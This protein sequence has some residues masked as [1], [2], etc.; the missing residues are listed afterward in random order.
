VV[1]GGVVVAGG[2]ARRM[3]GADKAMLRV[4][5]VTLLDRVLTAAAPVCRTLLVIGPPRAGVDVRFVQET[6]PGGG[7]VPAVKAALGAL[8]PSDAVLVLATDLPLLTTP[9]LEKLIAALDAGADAAAADGRNPLLAAYRRHP[10]AARAAALGPGDRAAS[11]LPPD[12]VA[13]DLG[14]ATLN[15]NT[16]ED[17][18][19]AEL[20]L[21][22]ADH[23]VAT[24]QWLRELV[25]ATVPDATERVYRGGRAFGYRHPAAGLFCVVFPLTETVHLS[26][27]HGAP[28]PDPHGLLTGTG[29]QVRYVDVRAPGDPPADLLIELIEAALVHPAS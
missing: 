10:L 6:E 26:F 9:H 15:V 27:E 18:E 23:V 29:R 16:P 12:V 28:L 5:G 21:D 17:L 11:L 13:V 14:P 20:L 8:P 7:P 24:A 1:V 25:A 3:G 2:A 22:H 4:G 19:A